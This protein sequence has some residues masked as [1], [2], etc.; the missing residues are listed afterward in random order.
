MVPVKEEAHSLCGLSKVQVVAFYT[1][2]TPYETEVQHLINS[3]QKR[4]I[5]YEIF[6]VS[7]K[8]T[9]V[10]NCGQKPTVISMALRAT[11]QDI[12][13]VDADAV[14]EGDISYF[15][16]LDADIG[17]HRLNGKELL[18]GTI[19]FRNTQKTRELVLLWEMAQKE[20][21]KEWDQKVLDRVLAT[22]GE[23]L[24][25]VIANIPERYCKIFDRK[26]EEPG[27]IIH[28]QAS[29]KY[30]DEIGATIT[31]LPEMFGMRIRRFSDGTFGIPRENKNVEKYFDEHCIRIPGERRWAPKIVQK[32]SIGDFRDYFDGKVCNIVG[33]GPSLDNLTCDAF[34][35][36]TEPVIAINEAI[37]MVE[38]LCLSSPTFCMQ[39][40][41]GLRNTCLPKKAI[42]FVSSQAAAHYGEIDNKW[43]FSPL[44]LNCSTSSLTVICAINLARKLGAKGFNFISFD[45]CTNRSV[46]YAKCVG[47]TPERG[48]K[49]ERFLTHRGRIE[50][51]TRGLPITFV[52]PM[53]S[54]RPEA[55][56]DRP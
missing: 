12:L 22:H 29:R 28:N 47:Y 3:L 42:L 50:Q 44:D 20:T 55:S 14:I 43:V 16:T 52:T 21:P 8:G 34:A 37:H 31:I 35:D 41:A 5:D 10:Q 19:F 23:K 26:S 45:S 38:K 32:F 24:G 9:W 25:I 13:Y 6:P 54:I 27:V 46:G 30:K 36:E 49:V 48:G 40:D 53:P 2:D 4:G 1:I 51:A 39:Q 11:S 15:D 7:N 33:K 18:S 17:F 56:L